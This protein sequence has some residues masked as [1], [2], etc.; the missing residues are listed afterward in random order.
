MI[1]S[2]VITY[3]FCESFSKGEIIQKLIDRK[4]DEDVRKKDNM[5]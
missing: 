4:D 1:A 5:P 3:Y 2:A